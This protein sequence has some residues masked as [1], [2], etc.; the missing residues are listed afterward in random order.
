MEN[1][2]I[3]ETI[4][5]IGLLKP[6]PRNAREHSEQQVNQIA[7]S[8]QEFGFNAPINVDENMQILAGYGRYLAAQKLKMPEVPVRMI[9][10]LTEIQKSLYIIADNQI[11][12]N[13][14]WD[15]E[16][17][18]TAVEEL[19]RELA[20][21]DLTALR[22]QEIDRLL[23]DL[24]PEEWMDED[25]PP[26]VSLSPITRA[27]EMWILDKHRVLCGDATLRE[28]YESV[29]KEEIANMVFTDS[30][31]NVDYKQKR[32]TGPAR[33]RSIANDDLG[34]GF[35][36]FL[37]SACVQLLAFTR[38]PV[39]MC[40]SSSELH[41][42]YRAFTSAGGYWSTFLIWAKDRFTMGRSD[43]QRQFE[44]VL[45]GWKKGESHYWCGARDEGDVWFVPKPKYNRMHPT[46]KPVAL[47]ERALRNSSRRGDLILDPFGGSGSTLIACEKTSRRA[48]LIELDPMYVDVII[49]RWELYTRREAQLEDDGR[50]FSAIAAERKRPAA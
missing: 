29:L 36:A 5:P 24:A 30:P 31:Y 3:K 38:G 26:D 47:V 14:T 48:A 9:H 8:I 37:Q 18:R 4:V 32:A 39:Y 40:M 13:S 50:N 49:R 15:E 34:E 20:N 41:T 25:D 11:A 35:G 7:Q 44:V 27:G 6:N 43:Y 12:L 45:Y 19:Q 46:M 22:P 17:L 1:S 21:L 28:S 2:M 23:A 16:K 42:L 33:V 10:G